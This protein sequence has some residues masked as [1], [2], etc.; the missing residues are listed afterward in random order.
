MSQKVDITKIQSLISGFECVPGRLEEVK[1][2]RKAKIYVD[3]AHTEASL[4]SV[5]KTLRDIDGT[6]RIITVFGAT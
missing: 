1:N 4:E 3:Y 6:N 5:L 2:Y